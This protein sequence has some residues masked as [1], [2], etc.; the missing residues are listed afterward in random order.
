MKP[1]EL[2]T[3]RLLLRMW[4]EETDFEPFAEMCADAEV[5][6]YLGGK[7]IDRLEAWRN[8][9]FHVGHWQMRGY[10]HFA[11]EEKST[12][13]FIGR[14]GFLDPVGWPAFEVGWTL[15]R[16]AWGKG[17]ATEGGRRALDYAFNEL[18][19]SH[20]ISLINP[21]NKGSIAVAERLGEKLEGETELFGTT[22][23][24]YGIDRTR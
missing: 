7:P 11:V 16:H 9:A 13:K 20:V 6:R 8:M 12:G 22:V 4:R 21:N 10:G 18:D 17:Y 15:A 5:M 23:L 1:V 2:E 24:I 19:K 3:D 14:I